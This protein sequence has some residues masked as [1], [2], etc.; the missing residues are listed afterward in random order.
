MSNTLS[1]D[2]RPPLGRGYLAAGRELALHRAGAGGPAVV[3]LPG[4]GLIGL[5]YLNVHEA[6]S[7]RTTSVLYDRAGTGWSQAAA[8]PRSAAEVAG[9]LRDLLRAAGV[10]PP[11]V[12]VGHSLGGAY[13]RRYAQLF[14]GEVAGLVL[15]DPAH[16][17]Y[18]S[19]SPRQNLVDQVRMIAALLGAAFNIKGFYRPMFE[20]MFALWP[21]SLRAILADYHVR[22]WRR[23][24]KR[25]TWTVRFW[26]RSATAATWPGADGGADRHGGRSVHGPVRLRATY[27]SALNSFIRR[28][29]TRRSP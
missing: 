24:R 15:L 13:A 29:S 7:R 12:L 6:I 19:G 18:L 5:D 16:E 28:R 2:G 22:S 17:G 14:P 25:G 1:A 20:R 10:T 11:Y 21:A 4:A 26:L 27:M 23:T 8:L 9:E 3:F